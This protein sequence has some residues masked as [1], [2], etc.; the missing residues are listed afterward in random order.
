MIRS[1]NVDRVKSI[2][3]ALLAGAVVMTAAP[4]LAQDIPPP[5]SDHD[6]IRPDRSGR[7]H[8]TAFDNYASPEGYA[9][10]SGE[11]SV[12]FYWP[13]EGETW[14]ETLR[15]DVPGYVLESIAALRPVFEGIGP[16]PERP[17]WVG[18][19]RE[20]YSEDASDERTIVGGAFDLAAEMLYLPTETLNGAP[21][22]RSTVAHEVAHAMSRIYNGYLDYPHSPAWLDEGGAEYLANVVYP[23][24]QNGECF[25][26]LYKDF[27]KATEVGLWDDARAYDAYPFLK[28]LSKNDT[29]VNAMLREFINAIPKSRLIYDYKLDEKW[30]QY[31]LE[32]WGDARYAMEA[33]S[34]QCDK[35]FPPNHLHFGHPGSGELS[36]EQITL[37]EYLQSVDPYAISYL[38]FRSDDS[39]LYRLTMEKV[40]GDNA[41]PDLRVGAIVVDPQGFKHVKMS[42]WPPD[43]SQPTEFAQFVP[44]SGE[45]TEHTFHHTGNDLAVAVSCVAQDPLDCDMFSPEVSEFGVSIGLPDAWELGQVRIN[46]GTEGTQQRFNIFGKMMLRAYPLDDGR[47]RVVQK[48]THF[49][50]NFEPQYYQDALEQ[51][52]ESTR[53][54]FKAGGTMETFVEESCWFLGKQILEIEEVDSDEWL[55]DTEKWD[56]RLVYKFKTTDDPITIN[57][58]H[59]FRC[60]PNVATN[61]T[62]ALL[63]GGGGA[64]AAAALMMPIARWVARATGGEGLGEDSWAGQLQKIFMGSLTWGIRDEGEISLA[65][66]QREIDDYLIVKVNDTLSLVYKAIKR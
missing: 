32:V 51:G 13:G 49:W 37:V 39:E 2:S 9:D 62:L 57:T 17:L 31:S 47:V 59:K 46:E 21:C 4:A 1:G 28:W 66:V 6:F 18:M 64:P 8:R 38:H 26:G 22:I 30:P 58:P 29:D 52:P 35:S 33:P 48:T 55:E 60:V 41:N 24:E 34:Y 56:Q 45:D 23:E 65:F 15:E 10:S 7:D 42:Q 11:A 3:C 54:A 12:Y 5:P 40:L 19:V 44:G 25:E 14:D 53:A 16:T 50:P 43:Q 63:L 27:G 36:M 20:M 61:K